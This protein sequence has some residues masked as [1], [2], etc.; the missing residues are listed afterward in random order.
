MLQIMWEIYRHKLAEMV[1]VT[2]VCRYVGKALQLSFS[3]FEFNSI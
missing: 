3:Y 1:F 2:R